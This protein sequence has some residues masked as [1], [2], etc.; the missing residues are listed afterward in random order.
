MYEVHRT[1]HITPTLHSQ[2]I[3]WSK[4]LCWLLE[5]IDDTLNEVRVE[6]TGF[7]SIQFYICLNWKSIDIRYFTQDYYVLMS[8]LS[9][10]WLL[11]YYDFDSLNC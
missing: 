8:H 5:E 2:H 3:K 10:H 1:F 4:K 7:Y 9:H 6:N 11:H